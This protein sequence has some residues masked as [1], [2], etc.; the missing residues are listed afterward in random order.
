MYTVK[1]SLNFAA[2]HFLA[3]YHGKCENL[4]G[5]NYTVEVSVRGRTLDSGGMLVDFG[6]L[7]NTLRSITDSLDHSLLNDRKEFLDNPSAERIA[8]YIFDRISV[9]Q[10]GVS[11]VTVWET[12][13]NCAS[14][15]PDEMP[16][17]P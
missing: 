13:K 12:E 3:D 4:H 9:G 6:V 10:S 2:A 8:R 17:L 5:H 15:E 11:M 7:K 16:D 1:I 14:Y